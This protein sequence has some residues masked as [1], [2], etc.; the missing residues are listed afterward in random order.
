MSASVYQQNWNSATHERLT[1]KTFLA[2]SLSEFLS[3][4]TKTLLCWI[5]NR[6]LTPT[7]LY[8][9]TPCWPWASPNVRTWNKRN[10][11]LK[12]RKTTAHLIVNLRVICL[13]CSLQQ[14]W[15][16]QRNVNLKTI[17]KGRAS[18][19]RGFVLKREWKE[20]WKPWKFAIRA[21][22]VKIFLPPYKVEESTYG[23]PPPRSCQRTPTLSLKDNEYYNLLIFWKAEFE[24][25]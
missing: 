1:A 20:W 3:Y 4:M 15:L 14:Q 11:P 19:V 12:Y 25:R 16:C 8:A 5:K 6:S 21:A 18:A 7:D 22:G 2:L 23:N 17:S 13:S 24:T 9:D 10:L